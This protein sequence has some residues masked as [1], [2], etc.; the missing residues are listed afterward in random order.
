M[1]LFWA[2]ARLLFTTH[3]L[4][5]YMYSGYPYGSSP[6]FWDVFRHNPYCLV[7]PTCISPFSNNGPAT[8]FAYH[9]SSFF[10]LALP[11]YFFFL[12]LLMILVALIV[13]YSSS[14]KYLHFALL[15]VVA[16]WCI[17][18]HNRWFDRL[19]QVAVN[20]GTGAEVAL[21]GE[22]VGLSLFALSV[23]ALTAHFTHRCLRHRGKNSREANRIG[24]V[25]A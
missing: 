15:A 6:T 5:L 4:P 18:E 1:D 22:Q 24:T 11:N 25:S 17:L 12:L 14:R 21:L 23:L 13:R 10:D 19:G 2:L 16:L 8:R 9:E 7:D 3:V 20:Q